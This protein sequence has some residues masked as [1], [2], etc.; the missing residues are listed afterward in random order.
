MDLK[1]K[2]AVVTGGGSGIGRATGLRLAR[3][4]AR[5][6]IAD[7]AD[8]AGAESVSM[9]KAAGGE[10]SFVHTD[11]SQ[12]EDVRKL[13]EGA[14][15]AYGGL[16]VLHNNAGILTGPRFPDSPPKYWSRAIDINIRGVLYGVYYGVP[17]LKRRGGGVIINTASTSGLKPHFSDPVYAATKAAIVNLTRS[18]VFLQEEAGIRVNCV[19]PGRV[20]TELEEHAEAGLDA[21]ERQNFKERRRDIHGRPMLAPDDIA[22]AVLTLIQDSTLNGKAYKIVAGE[23]WELL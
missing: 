2:V 17:A 1:N 22:T 13:I 10:A 15:S 12:E 14:E 4:G 21:Q 9:I 18:L 20:R 6:M 3:E 11:V 16:D 19:C 8:E 23:D 7:C 5:V